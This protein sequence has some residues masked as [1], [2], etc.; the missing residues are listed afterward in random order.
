MPTAAQRDTWEG[1]ELVPDLHAALPWVFGPFCCTKMF[2]L[3][4]VMGARLRRTFSF[5]LRVHISGFEILLHFPP[6]CR[7]VSAD[8]YSHVIMGRRDCVSLK[9]MA[10]DCLLHY[11]QWDSVVTI[12][13][14]SIP[15]KVIVWDCPHCYL[16]ALNWIEF[17]L[18][19]MGQPQKC[20][21]LKDKELI[22]FSGQQ[23]GSL[24]A[25]LENVFLLFKTFIS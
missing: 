4:W 10:R 24:T 20:S 23:L 5:C 18:I 13:R 19:G 15:L 8:L 16:P 25:C 14:D 21:L 17:I 22:Q 1:Q 3:W 9:V 6:S 2:Q 11:F 7:W 12:L